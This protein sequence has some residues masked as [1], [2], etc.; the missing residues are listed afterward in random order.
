MD[1]FTLRQALH[2]YYA[3]E[4]SLAYVAWIGL[5]LLL[6]GLWLIWRH[7][8]FARGLG[9]AALLGS[10]VLGAG[11]GLYVRSL[12]ERAA[13]SRAALERD[14]PKW[15]SD[16][17]QQFSGMLQRFRWLRLVDAILVGAGLTVAVTA[18]KRP[19]L[20]GAGLGIAVQAAG[21]WWLEGVNLGR[22]EHYAQAIDAFNAQPKRERNPNALHD[23]PTFYERLRWAVREEDRQF[24]ASLFEYPLRLGPKELTN[25]GDLIHHYDE[26]FDADTRYAVE[27]GR[28]APV[29]DAPPSEGS[30]PGDELEWRGP[31]LLRRRC[32]QPPGACSVRIIGLRRE[33]RTSPKSPPNPT[34]SPEPDFAPAADSAK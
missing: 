6:V 29:G 34:G 9:F 8:G 19:Q 4:G 21:L 24:V 18:H 31:L 28:P 32:S 20:R 3:G 26:L 33:P 25:V 14:P 5:A 17:Q 16:Q 13:T 11:G 1:K 22:A 12:D 10:L 2:D 27:A 15:K 23:I 7:R 30:L